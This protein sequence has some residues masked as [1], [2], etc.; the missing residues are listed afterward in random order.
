MSSTIELISFS[1]YFLYLMWSLILILTI[2]F[3]P[4]TIF[5]TSVKL[6]ISILE[7]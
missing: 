1:P 2:F 5:M 6:V 3:T 4:S 7:V